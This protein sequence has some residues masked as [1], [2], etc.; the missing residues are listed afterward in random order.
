MNCLVISLM[1][2]LQKIQIPLHIPT[3][4]LCWLT[5]L[6]NLIRKHVQ[7]GFWELQCLTGTCPVR[8][9]RAIEIGLFSQQ[10]RLL[11][12][13]IPL[14]SLLSLLKWTYY[15]HSSPWTYVSCVLGCPQPHHTVIQCTY[16]IHP[17]MLKCH[18]VGKHPCSC[19]HYLLRL[20]NSFLQFLFLKSLKQQDLAPREAAGKQ[21][22]CLGSYQ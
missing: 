7:R 10:T 15:T 2:S 16:W 8:P 14:I 22:L 19:T 18:L 5:C 12:T 3:P 17:A 20:S 6:Y 11:T 9:C 1:N 4:S 13:D 21:G